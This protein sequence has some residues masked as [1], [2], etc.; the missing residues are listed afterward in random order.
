MFTTQKLQRN[1]DAAE[2]TAAT[3]QVTPQVA[4]NPFDENTWVTPEKLAQVTPTIA[5]ENLEGKVETA[6]ET[7][8]QPNYNDFVKNEFGFD[9]IE[10]AKQEFE[11]YKK[12]KE[13]P[14][15]SQELKF[16]NEQ[17]KKVFEALKEGKIDDVYE[18]L[19]TQKKVDKLLNAEVNESTAAE[20]VKLAM[21][22]KYKE[23]GLTE[24]EINYKFNQQFNLPKQPKQGLDETD[25]EY[26]ETLK[27]WQE[28][29]D[30]VKQ[31]L[32]IEGKVAKQEIAKIK[33]DLV[34]PTIEQ[35]VQEQTI[36]PKE[37]EK[38]EVIRKQYES[39]LEIE[40]KNFNG[41]SVT[42]KCGDAE[43]PIA[44]TPTEEYKNSLTNRLKDFTYD[45][46]FNS[47]WINTDGT[48]N[49]SKVM[50][51]IH[52]LENQE[53]AFQK[54]ANESAAKMFEYIKKTT[55]NIKLENEPNK[56]TFQPTAKS[57]LEVFAEGVW[58]DK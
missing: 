57:S 43:L 37:V 25:D 45:E 5:Q 27:E 26:Q 8:T 53:A 42:A 10:V 13:T 14:P 19:A 55:S 22:Q 3:E 35:K 52:L 24:D 32:I 33:S 4:A 2:T 41:I 54:V 56:G 6:I 20:L 44:F 9:S 29:V 11:N 38:L 12:L 49:V 58:N 30:K 40:G 46:Y 50:N 34:L 1:V 47:R 21:Q 31:A 39:S 16:E 48:V 23:I 15:T 7:K 28:N 51:D 17:S 18:F 36:D